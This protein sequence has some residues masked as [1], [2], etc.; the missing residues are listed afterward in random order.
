MGIDELLARLPTDKPED[1]SC[2]VCGDDNIVVVI[3]IG[4]PINL[5]PKC[6]G[7]LE[8]DIAAA[9]KGEEQPK[10]DIKRFY[11]EV[12]VMRLKINELELSGHLATYLS[13]ASEG[14]IEAQNAL[15]HA[16]EVEEAQKTT[17]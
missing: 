12:A 10:N 3:E 11:E 1:E 17:I 8:R 4:G 14:L 7:R 16:L 13:Y 6:L 2:R 5:C 9:L 15:E